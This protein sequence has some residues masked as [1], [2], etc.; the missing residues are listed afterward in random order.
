MQSYQEWVLEV[1]SSLHFIE[2]C[3]ISLMIKYSTLF[4]A[5]ILMAAFSLLV[6]CS[7]SNEELSSGS[8]KNASSAD[9]SQN[10]LNWNKLQKINLLPHQLII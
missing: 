4:S 1:C 9:I 3:H 7:N 6:G 8:L 10:L 5:S 2:I